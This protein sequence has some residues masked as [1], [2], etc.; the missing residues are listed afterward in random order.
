MPRSSRRGHKK[1]NRPW[2]RGG[3][4]HLC[5]WGLGGGIV[6]R[7]EMVVGR[8]GKVAGYFSA[9]LGEAAGGNSQTFPGRSG[10][11]VCMIHYYVFVQFKT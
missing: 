10:G 2:G 5:P 4:R 3:G 9:R 7:G 6:G 8:A 1:A 11:G